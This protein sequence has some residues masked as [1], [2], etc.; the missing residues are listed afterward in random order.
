MKQPHNA[1]EFDE[2]TDVAMSREHLRTI[3]KAITVT[4]NRWL[5]ILGFIQYGSE[6]D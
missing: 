2:L 4:V 6:K 1:G 3:T 5:A